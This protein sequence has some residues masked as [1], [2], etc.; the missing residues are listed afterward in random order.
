MT[1]TRAFRYLPSG[2]LM[3]AVVSAMS[4]AAISSGTARAQL[5]DVPPVYLS[6]HHLAVIYRSDVTPAVADSFA[7]AMGL[8]A[9]RPAD[10]EYIP[11]PL[12]MR[13]YT[14][15]RDVLPA[16]MTVQDM[17]HRLRMRWPHIVYMAQ[18]LDR[19]FGVPS[20][21]E[22]LV[23]FTENT[24]WAEVQVVLE[25]AGLTIDRRGTGFALCQVDRSR[26]G[27]LV[28][29]AMV[30][31]Q[32]RGDHPQLVTYAEPNT[33][34]YARPHD[35]VTQDMPPSDEAIRVL[36]SPFNP[37][38]AIHYDVTASG[39]VSLAIYN[40]L[41]QRVRTL[42]ETDQASGV[43][44]VTWNGRDDSGQRVASGVYVIRLS[45]QAQVKAQRVTVMY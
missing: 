31:D 16:H 40:T 33:Y 28:T 42:V 18:T 23:R 12:N 8:A 7:G 2:V 21:D 38:T 6:H 15:N 14:L 22:L 44:Q 24:P 45:T 13:V 30:S 1:G 39:D 43:Y 41:G 26:I 32:L 17:A 4:L 20:P 3:A 25:G 27:Q 35:A 9:Y 37:N 11:A 29:A 19:E 10:G 5:V 36:P 34:W